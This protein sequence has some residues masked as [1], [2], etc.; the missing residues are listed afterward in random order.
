MTHDSGAPGP[1]RVVVADDDAFVRAGIVA[2]LTTVDD[3][4]VIAEADDGHAAIEVTERFTPDVLLLDT[5]MPRLDGIAALT[6]T[7][8]RHQGLP[9]AML[10]T[11]SDEH[12]VASA[13]GA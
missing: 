2:L 12:F 11:F 8:S 5:Q 7:A 10:T 6:E 13:I 9:V 4:E 1:V 3:I